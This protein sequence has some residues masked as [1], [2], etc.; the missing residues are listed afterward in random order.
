MKNL[1][2]IL[3]NVIYLDIETTGLDEK[4]SEIIEIGAVK[5]KNNEIT[6]YETLIKPRGR[7][8]AGIYS[9]CTGLNE[10]ELLSA[11]SLNAVRSE[12]VEFL[13]DLPLI[14]H[15]GNFEKKFLN[16]H[17]PDIKNEILDSMELIAILE[18]YRK[19]YNLDS[20]IKNMTIM[21][22]DELHRGLDDSINTLKVVNAALCRQWD[23]EEHSRKKNTLYMEIKKYYKH[24]NNWQWTECLQ[25][26]PFLNYE[27]Y[28]YVSYEE[29]RHKELILKDVK[30]DYT[31]YEELLKD[32]D[33]WNNGGDFG[34]VF[35][36][37]QL[38]FSKKIRENFQKEERIFI[39]APTGSGKTFAYVIIAAI[40]AYLNKQKHRKDD[41]SF[42]I[43]TNTK[44]LQNQLIERDIPTILKK[45]RLDDKLNYGAMKG[46]GNY[47]CI[48]RLRKCEELELSQEGNLALLFLNR[49]C[50]NGKY[51]DSENISFWAHKHFMLDDYLKDV[52]CD[53]DSCNLDK[54]NKP[55]YLRK[56]YNELPAE[57][58]TVINHSL[59]SCWPYCEKKKIN[60]II[61]DEGHNLMEKCYD[62]FAE[63]FCYKE[64]L[65]LLDTIE[66]GHPS[67]IMLLN[68]LNLSYGYR[69][70]IEKDKLVYLVKEIIVNM[71]IILNDFRS[72]RL[73]SGE[74]NFNTEFFVPRDDL[75][76]ITKAVGPEISM[77]K[78]SIYPLYKMLNDY[79]NNIVGDDEVSGET[80][81]KTVSDYIS[82]IK[83]TF[84]MLD[85]FLESSRFFA[86]ILEVDS[87][88][89]DFK[90][91]TVPLNVG[92][93]VNEHM[94]KDVKSTT[95][96]SATLRIENS[97]SR[98]KK[99]LG[100]EKA[101][102]FLI[103]S[104]FNLRKRTK[105]FALKDM[106]RYDEPSYIKNVSKF[107][108]ETSEKLHGHMLVLFNNNARRNSVAEELE[109]LIRGTK[110][111]VHT[112]KKSIG[113][114]NDKN[115]Q[116]IILGSQGFFEGIDVPGDAL[117]CVMLDK[118]PNYSPEYPI[119]RAITTYQNK[120]YRDVNYPQLC[121]KVKQIYGRLIR[122]IYDY[123]YFIILDPGENQFTIRNIERDLG[124]PNIEMDFS[125]NIL[126]RIKN[127]YNSWRKENLN[128]I[129]TKMRS[130][131]MDI[132]EKFNDESK[133]Y[134]MFWE[135]VKVEEGKYYFENLDYKLNG[136]L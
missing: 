15:N 8:P 4:S 119:L 103:P 45:L 132:K 51:G 6:T 41:S 88:Y 1:K 53:S 20:L 84:D 111:E 9:L 128:M 86:K 17:I 5:I 65:E 131:N 43:S 76:G 116:V 92:E 2:S 102:E 35:R 49:L 122:S 39:E 33:I 63:E 97:F 54:C 66:N 81:Y 64:F 47:I 26:P 112:N 46:K 100:Q 124:G 127:D 101:K 57:N 37:N 129:I 125:K 44:E 90:L 50:E 10:K 89:E 126:A 105:I 70:T 3:D 74:Y 42:I 58:I 25:K 48:E 61:I 38:E 110:I 98:I 135:L 7:V 123:G 21:E 19:E 40:G 71:N 69:E 134:K 120:M 95:F 79:L 82:K 30:I 117:N 27:E 14:C 115:R 80:D 29:N 34:Y 23:R 94:L 108:F 59:L 93:L 73:V 22:K 136:K 85:K 109:M 91:R 118:F 55:C 60:H 106:G 62:F 130:S 75:K 77:L 87:K 96:L 32:E 107:I 24:L 133:K 56:R 114:L 12:V 18:P 104:V 13:E 31:K 52:T 99:H 16:Y 78:E 121:I 28:P 113:A 36:K 72:M 68:S 67:I 83:G 11:R